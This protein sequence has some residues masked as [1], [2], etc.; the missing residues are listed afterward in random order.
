MDLIIRNGTI[1]TAIDT[2][3][4]DIGV[5]GGKIAQIGR[6]LSYDASTTVVDAGGR[7]VF[8]GGVDTHV[9]LDTP[10]MGTVTAD[11]YLTGTIAAACGGTTSIV[12]FCFQVPGQSLADAIAGWQAKAEGRAAIDYGFHIVVADPTDAV[13]QELAVLPEQGITSFKL[14]MAYKDA[15]MADDWTIIRVLEQARKH[16]ALVMVH[17][18]NGDAAH[19]LQQR[20]LAAGKT[21]PKYHLL[22]RPPR[23]EAEAVAR[24]IALAEI[25]GAPIFIVHLSCGEALE[26]VARGRSRGVQVFAETCPHYLYT[27]DADFDRPGFESAKYCYSPPPRPESNHALLWRALANGTLQSVGSDH[28]PFNFAGQKELGRDDFTKIPSGAPG[29]EERMMMIYQGVGQDRLTLNRFVELTATAPAK[30]FGLYPEKGTIAIG[31]DADLTIWNHTAELTLTASALHQN[32]DYTVYEGRRVRGLPETVLLRGE[33][34]V[35]NREFVG[36]AG[37]GRF[38]RRKRFMM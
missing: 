26:E 14:F 25:A 23:I 10:V 27:S 35:E 37:T 18:E 29:I 36:R 1:V 24:A 34:I 2:Y 7:Y 6:E 8:P 3:Q 9:H 30:L 16:G 22:S 38:I 21:A 33:V 19:L 20:F 28:A 17:A 12:D 13:L 32:V 31:S 11:D 15:L 4:A 5:R